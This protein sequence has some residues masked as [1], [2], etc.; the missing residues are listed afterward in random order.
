MVSGRNKD[1]YLILYIFFLLSHKTLLN[2]ALI[3]QGEPSVVAHNEGATAFR[4]LE[5]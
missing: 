3:H 5:F 2:G 4:H 1:I